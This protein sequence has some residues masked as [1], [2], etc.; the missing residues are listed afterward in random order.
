MLEFGCAVG[1]NLFLLKLKRPDVKIIGCD[2]NAQARNLAHLLTEDWGVEIREAPLTAKDI[3]DVDTIFTTFTLAYMEYPFL[4]EHLK[5]F[6]DKAKVLV[7][8]EPTVLTE[9][10]NMKQ[11]FHGL[12]CP[13]WAYAYP[14]IL[15][16]NGR[17][18]EVDILSDM[19]T[20]A[21]VN[22]ITI[23]R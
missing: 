17:D 6:C 3:P 13:G 18:V 22:A 20:V 1:I 16:K 9:D 15:R 10:A 5:V 11:D 23:A 14:Y 8:G 7:L 21:S 12:P 19:K 2:I 4:M